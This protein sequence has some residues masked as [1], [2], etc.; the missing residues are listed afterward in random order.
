MT[1]KIVKSESEWRRE[2]S[3]EEYRIAREKGTEP[4][5]SHK[6]FPKAPGV[7]RCVACGEAL[8]ESDS[9]YESGCGWP[10]FTEP[11]EDSAVEE[12]E[13]LSFGM[14]RTEVTCSRCDAHLGHVF[15]DG[16]TDRGGMRYCINGTVLRFEPKDDAVE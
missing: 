11:R 4:A 10:S 2:L 3:P 6:G 9:K 14:R 12:H 1:D 16:P 5:F 15:P 8:F 13:D 7:F